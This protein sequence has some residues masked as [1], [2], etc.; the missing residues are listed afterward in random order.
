M[1]LEKIISTIV[2]DVRSTGVDL[3]D[4]ELLM[5][6]ILAHMDEYPELDVLENSIEVG[7][8][9]LRQLMQ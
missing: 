8:S 2:D 7:T 3:S 9:V 1:E 5:H 6:W 4:M